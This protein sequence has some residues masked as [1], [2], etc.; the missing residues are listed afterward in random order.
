MMYRFDVDVSYSTV[1]GWTG[2]E[3]YRQCF[4]DA[5]GMKEYDEVRWRTVFDELMCLV[6]HEPLMVALFEKV[7][8]RVGFPIYSEK[9]DSSYEICLMFLFSYTYFEGFHKVL[10]DFESGTLDDTS[11]SY[12]A[13]MECIE[14]ET[15]GTE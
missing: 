10:K 15:M 6:A 9:L 3:L 1:D 11:P 12:R 8:S 2:D 14:H 4:L 7:S 5:F 13:L